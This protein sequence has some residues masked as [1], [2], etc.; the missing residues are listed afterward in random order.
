MATDSADR[1]R[2]ARYGVRLPVQYHLSQKGRMA[3]SG[4]GLTLNMSSNG[5]SFRCRG[6]LPVGAHIDIV[7]DWPA[8]YDDLYP[9]DLLVTGFI[10]RSNA[11][12]TAVRMTSRKF[13]VLE[14][15]D[16]PY[17]ALA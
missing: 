15:A 11:H 1:R 13:R 7:I 8:R 3:R 14:L 5:V 10:V 6:P 9:V 16:Q 4:G 17:L 12:H 2:N